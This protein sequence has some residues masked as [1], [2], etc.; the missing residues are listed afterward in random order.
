LESQQEAI[1]AMA[2]GAVARGLDP[3]TAAA[4]VYGSL[5]RIEDVRPALVEE[6]GEERVRVIDSLPAVAAAAEQA[7]IEFVAAEPVSDVA[8]MHA[9]VL[10]EHKKLIADADSLANRGLLDAGRVDLGRSVQGHRAT[11]ASTLILVS[12]MR[13][14]WSRISGKTP[15]TLEDLSV[16]ESKAASMS[17]LLG[18]REQG[19]NRHRA[20]D[21]RARTLMLLIRSYGEVRRMIGFVRFWHDDADDIAPSL[22]A[23][24][25]KRRSASNGVEKDAEGKPQPVPTPSGPVNGGGPFID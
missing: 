23:G 9:E 1:A 5:P 12:L 13:E 3:S 6:F 14:A 24:R 17:R 11:A 15:V 18:Q 4:V 10:A 19:T 7:Q 16:A 21:Q 22:W 20:A 8:V 25:G 2:E